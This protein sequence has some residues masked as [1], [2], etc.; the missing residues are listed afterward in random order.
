MYAGNGIQTMGEIGEKPRILIVDD[1]PSVRF[2]LK[3]LLSPEDYNLILLD[4]GRE[5]LRRFDEFEPD[6]ILLDVMMPIMEGFEVCRRLR[7]LPG[8]KHVPVI[9]LTVLNGREEIVRGLDAGADEFLT[10]PVSGPELR[11]RVRSMIRIKTQYDELQAALRLHGDLTHM[12]VHDMRDPLARVFL[13][14]DSLREL[15]H[16]QKA[17]ELVEQARN[18]AQ[19]LDAYIDEILLLAKSEA[20]QLTLKRQDVVLNSLIVEVTGDYRTLAEASDVQLVTELPEASPQL[21][22]DVNLFRRM[23]DNL[24]SNAVKYSPKDSRVTVKVTRIEDPDRSVRIQVMDAGPGIPEE[25][26]ETIFDKF[27]IVEQKE[28][29]KSQIGLGLPFCKMVAEAHGGRIVA[30]ANH[31]QG[32][33]FTVEI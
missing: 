20:G 25:R 12:I 19:N 5:L 3:S 17:V 6:V 24:L 10:K 8:G 4:N 15:V 9:L 27:E 30:T 32:S 16:E 29:V 22:V 26:R 28:K 21:T 14:L 33:V 23:L 11:A 13:Y 2:T 7:A 31:P 18:G 1:E